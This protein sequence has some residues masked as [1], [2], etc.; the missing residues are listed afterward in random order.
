M[1]NH[2]F[3]FRVEVK[4]EAALDLLRQGGQGYDLWAES[5]HLD[6]LNRQLMSL[7]IPMKVEEGTEP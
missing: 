1:G 2:V 5:G 3:S 6:K 4:L 7:M